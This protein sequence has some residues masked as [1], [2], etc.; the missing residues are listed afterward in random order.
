MAWHSW[1]TVCGP[2]RRAYRMASRLAS[3]R[4]LHIGSANVAYSLRHPAIRRRHRPPPPGDGRRAHPAA[5]TA[6]PP[7]AGDLTTGRHPGHPGSVTLDAAKRQ[8]ASQSGEWQPHAVLADRA[9]VA[10][11][12]VTLPVTAPAPDLMSWPSCGGGITPG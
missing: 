1:V 8:A 5:G 9:N 12:T 4:A 6:L 10:A 11:R 7:S 3:F 2:V